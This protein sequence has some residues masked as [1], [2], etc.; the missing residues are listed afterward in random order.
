MNKLLLLLTIA[1]ALSSGRPGLPVEICDNALDDDGDGLIDLNDPDCDCPLAEPVSLI[2]NPS[3]EDMNCCPQNRSQLNCADT[4]IQASEATTDYLNTCGWM[5]W[6]NLPPPLP[7]PDGN[8]CVGYR[9]GR[10]QMEVVPNWKE[11]AG[12]CLLGPLKKGV[13]YRF[14]FYVGFTYAIH[15]PPTNVTFFGT[16]SCTHLPFGIGNQEFG[17]PT[18]DPDWIQLG[19][20]PASGVR[21]WVA[22]EI[23]IVPPVDI[24]AIAIGP[25]CT[26]LYSDVDIYYFFDNLI[27]AEQSAFEF[28]IRSEGHPCSD[29]FTLSVV[30]YDSLQYQWYKDGVALVGETDA[31]LHVSTG[32]GKYIVRIISDIECKISEP[33]IYQLPV[34]RTSIAEHIC[35]GD[36]FYFGSQTLTETGYYNETFPDRNGCDSVVLLT[37]NV[38]PNIA[39]TLNVRIFEGET[40]KIGSYSFN[41]PGEYLA[42][43]QTRYDCDSIVHVNLSYYHVYIPNAF[44]PNDDGINDVFSIMGG[45]ELVKISTLKVFDR[46]GNLVYEGADLSPSS[47]VQGWNGKTRGKPVHN[48]VYTYLTRLLMDDGKE[49]LFSGSVTLLR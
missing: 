5:G 22:T 44:S 12:A 28:Q 39:D 19:A 41:A 46:W 8:G 15:S 34:I 36:V 32:E 2:P 31:A 23:N 48:G 38:Q 35:E 43:F 26:Q 1:L 25:D 9:N 27:L 49:R 37:L 42:N 10:Y 18:N 4:W 16:P 7:F 20:V 21:T 40:F 11:Y 6:D 29:A 30:D 24:N 14:K 33:Y 17:C 13:N 45:P 47:Y 3:F